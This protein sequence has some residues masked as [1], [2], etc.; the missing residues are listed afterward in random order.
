METL[1]RDQVVEYLKSL[2]GEN[3][4][5]SSNVLQSLSLALIADAS[6]S[7]LI[8]ENDGVEKISQ[9]FLSTKDEETKRKAKILLG[10]LE[11]EGSSAYFESSSFHEDHDEASSSSTPSSSS[12]QK[13]T[14]FAENSFNVMASWHEIEKTFKPKDEF[15]HAVKQVNQFLPPLLLKKSLPSILQK[16]DVYSLTNGAPGAEMTSVLAVINNVS[17]PAVGTQAVVV[18]DSEQKAQE[19]LALFDEAADRLKSKQNKEIPFAEVPSMRKEGQFNATVLI[20]STTELARMMEKKSYNPQ[21]LNI[22]IFLNAEQAVQSASPTFLTTF[23]ETLPPLCQRILFTPSTSLRTNDFASHFLR[24]RIAVSRIK[25]EPALSFPSAPRHLM[26]VL[27]KEEDSSEQ[28]AHFIAAAT[29]CPSA[30]PRRALVFCSSAADI[31]SVGECLS[32][33]DSKVLFLKQNAKWG[34]LNKI[35]PLVASGEKEVIL[36]SSA[37]VP[38]F[39]NFGA[40]VVVSIGAPSDGDRYIDLVRTAAPTPR[41][42]IISIVREAQKEELEHFETDYN[43]IFRELSSDLSALASSEDEEELWIENERRR[44]S[45]TD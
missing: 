26:H 16:K 6:V 2:N 7:K 31:Q 20:G 4:S 15:M 10:L 18:C 32:K 19:F 5:S 42:A 35:E 22:A 11:N 14:L 28:I 33:T 13:P 12:A 41:P 40:S 44:R 21:N 27:G 39:G 36:C 24:P 38:S 37:L 9:I 23:C 17:V 29:S 8:F 43:V 30:Q 25:M 1:N 34:E 3:K 45:S